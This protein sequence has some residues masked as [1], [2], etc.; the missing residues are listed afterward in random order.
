MTNKQVNTSFIVFIVFVFIAAIL[1]FIGTFSY[2]LNFEGKNLFVP[3][4]SDRNVVPFPVL[5][6]EFDLS[7]ADSIRSDVKRYRGSNELCSRRLLKEYDNYR[8]NFK[9]I[10][11]NVPNQSFVAKWDLPP[12][13][14]SYTPVDKLCMN[15]LDAYR[16]DYVIQD[17]LLDKNSPTVRNIYTNKMTNFY[18]LFDGFDSGHD[19]RLFKLI[20]SYPTLT[21]YAVKGIMSGDMANVGMV[22]DNR[23]PSNLKLDHALFQFHSN[24][25]KSILIGDVTCYDLAP[26]S[27][28]VHITNKHKN[29]VNDI[30]NAD[31]MIYDNYIK[32]IP[33]SDVLILHLVGADHLS[34]C[35]GRNTPEMSNIMK[36]YNTFVKELMNQY[37]KYKNYMIFFFGDHGQKESGSHGDDSIEE[38]ETFLMVR[39]DMRLHSV[40]RDFCPISET[41]QAYRL[42]HSA[43]NGKVQL[44]FEYERQFTQ[45]ISTTSSLLTNVPIPF[46]SVG[47]VIPNSVP[48]IRDNHGNIDYNLSD[49]YL[50]QLYHVN[51]HHILRILD[52]L[53]QNKD[54]KLDQQFL[55]R[56]L[57]NRMKLV[58]L[59]TLLRLFD[60]N[61]KFKSKIYNTIS[62]NKG[63][64]YNDYI[65]VCKIIIEESAELIRLS[66][67]SFTFDYLYISIIIKYV[68]IVI[69]IY[70]IA[71]SYYFTIDM[72]LAR[73]I[74]VKLAL[75]LVLTLV[76]SCMFG[77]K[78]DKNIDL[79]VKMRI[80]WPLGVMKT[81]FIKSQALTRFISNFFVIEDYDLYF[82]FSIIF[83]VIL[84]V[85]FLFHTITFIYKLYIGTGNV[86]GAVDMTTNT[87]GYNSMTD[88]TGADDTGHNHTDNVEDAKF[89]VRMPDL[90]RLMYNIGKMN[91]RGIIL[92]LYSVIFIL[93][94]VS[95]CA[96]YSHDTI[97]R[98]EFVIFMLIECVPYMLQNYKTP[99]CKL[100]IRH[101]V[102]AFI[103]LKIS[104]LFHDY[105]LFFYSSDLPTANWLKKEYF[106]GLFEVGA[107][108]L[109]VFYV[110]LMRF[111]KKFT[112]P[113]R[114]GLE[115]FDYIVSESLKL[116]KL[117][118]FMKIVFLIHYVLILVNY[119]LTTNRS[120]L[121]L[122]KF[123]HNLHNAY[124]MKLFISTLFAWGVLILYTLTTILMLVNPRNIIIEPGEYRFI[125]FLLYSIPNLSYLLFLIC[126]QKKAFQTLLSLII[127]Y[128]CCKILVNTTSKFHLSH[129]LLIQSLADAAYFAIG[130]IDTF[131]NLNFQTGF[132]FVNTYHQLISDS[133]V[134]FEVVSIHILFSVVLMLIYYSCSNLQITDALVLTGSDRLDSMESGL[135]FNGRRQ[136]VS[137]KIH[138]LTNIIHIITMYILLVSV[139]GV[140]V[141]VIIMKLHQVPCIA[142][143]SFPKAL[144]VLGKSTAMFVTQLLLFLIGAIY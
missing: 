39:S 144:F 114:V 56:V 96:L 140:S 57:K 16:F 100:V 42:H 40:E 22:S 110:M 41:P 95:E 88:N 21:I 63:N 20:S 99:Q 137:K 103:L 74:L 85:V 4:F 9:H 141:L 143:R 124:N 116:F 122:D 73:K 19:T 17:P 5:F 112:S 6:K 102:L 93:V 52:L 43:L 26:D 79:Y 46:H 53:T 128:N 3:Y 55:S 94:I 60:L 130:N 59:Y 12:G 104:S 38:M 34:H 107:F 8:Y 83:M 132:V 33:R 131:L 142:F 81:L 66:T 2:Y 86:T 126:G 10:F 80:V 78:L 120:L 65:Q 72:A 76:L 13:W 71:A 134:L 67:R 45:D 136:V 15:L 89:D 29:T 1:D 139:L 113:D 77:V 101:L 64:L 97:S 69:L 47:S 37:E 61:S 7:N 111:I 109:T 105:R 32:Y 70:S 125:S 27:F 24:G 138:T 106:L 118:K 75:N 50:V 82:H 98:H 49:K 23:K 115:K 36:N 123:I 135:K 91:I 51:V 121:G 28:D 54:V 108:S 18:E 35:G 48:L 58:N 117:K 30:Y 90:D 127:L 92:V 87:T 84:T 11:Q 129:T 31:Q 119:G 68:S 44:S 25:L 133:S 14:L 62:S